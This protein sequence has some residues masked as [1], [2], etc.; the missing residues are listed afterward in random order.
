MVANRICPPAD[1][2]ADSPDTAQYTEK[3]FF[4]LLFEL[5]RTITVA[6]WPLAFTDLLH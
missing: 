6:F 5:R 4:L 1:S 3:A 2:I